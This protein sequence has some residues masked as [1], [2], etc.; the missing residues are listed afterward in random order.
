VNRRQYIDEVSQRLGHRNLLWWGF[1]GS[2]AGILKQIP[3]FSHVFSLTAP[4]A[5]S[6]VPQVCLETLQK[7]RVDLHTYDIE[8]DCSEG[9][10]ILHRLLYS[11]LGTPAAVIPYRSDLFLNSVA[12]PQIENI[13]YLGLFNAQ[14]AAFENKPWVETG[15]RNHGVRTISWR[16]CGFYNLPDLAR[17]V[18]EGPV[19]LRFYPYNAG[20]GGA[21][22]FVLREQDA[23]D[24]SLP[25]RFDALCSI[26]RYLE[27]NIPLNIHACVFPDGT[28]SFHGLSIQLIG[29]PACTNHALGYC[30]NDYTQIREIDVNIVNEVEAMTL[31]VGKWLASQ[32]YLGVFGLDAVVYHDHIYFSEINPRFQGSSRLSA[33]QDCAHDRPDVYLSH[34]GAFLGMPAPPYIPLREL[35][36]R[37]RGGSQ[38]ICYNRSQI[39]MHR[40]GNLKKD[41]RQL[42]VTLLPAPEVEVV[43]EGML[44]LAVSQ[45][46]VTENGHYLFDTCNQ[47][48]SDLIGL[49][50]PAI[51]E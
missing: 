28:V 32:G 47:E 17:L 35:V 37:Q 23:M 25:S 24:L 39:S 50:Q 45:D 9:P 3:Q 2:D 34:M 22:L 36:R 18:K 49:F 1:R 38:I 41:S 6:T 10:G 14:Q 29:I 7:K 5:G 16:Y 8:L 26:S 31:Q 15:L 12:L 48:I 33:E 21:N 51:L 30:G 19:V 11:A 13:V 20:R 46:K 40:T 43:P 42:T 44:F 4:L 27:P